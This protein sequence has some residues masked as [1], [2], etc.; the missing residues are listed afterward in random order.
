MARARQSDAWDRAADLMALT[1]NCHRAKRTSRRYHRHDFHP[2]L[3]R[4]PARWTVKDLAAD[5][6][7]GQTLKQTVL[8]YDA[9]GG[10]RT[11]PQ[12]DPA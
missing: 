11:V 5:L 6:Y 3:E 4:P 9:A 8:R 2:Y 10:C 1:A 7:P 12:P